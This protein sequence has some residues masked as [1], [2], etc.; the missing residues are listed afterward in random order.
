MQQEFGN[1]QLY[2]EIKNSTLVEWDLE[3]GDVVHYKQNS[4][5]GEIFRRAT[6]IGSHGEFAN[7]T[8]WE[9][10]SGG[11]FTKIPGQPELQ[12]FKMLGAAFEEFDELTGTWQYMGEDLFLMAN[13][14][15]PI[16]PE[17]MFGGYMPLY[18]PLGYTGEDVENLLSLLSSVFDESSFTEDHVSM[19]NTTLDRGF[20]TFVDTNTGAIT[21]MGGWMNMPGGDDTTWMYM[22]IYPMY[23]ETLHSGTTSIPVPNDAVSEIVVSDIEIITDNDGIELV[24]AILDYNPIN[25]SISNGT[26]LYYN[27]LLITNTTGLDN[28]TF[29]I[30]FADSFDLDFYDLTFWAWNMSGNNE[31]EAAPPSATDMFVYDYADNSLTIIFPIGGGSGPISIIMAVSYIYA[32]PV[33]LIPKGEIPGFPLLMILGF[34]SLGAI[35]LIIKQRKKIKKIQL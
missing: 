8:Q 22:T 34:L 6:I 27:D 25:T 2:L 23:N 30:K 1:V 16:A 29:Y 19:R 15:W 10:D 12:F 14:Y 24:D 28:L 11:L 7:L 9:L 13:I 31:W 17:A 26:V 20:D 21:F 4:R 3:V 35:A 18:I 32:P 5:D 33:E